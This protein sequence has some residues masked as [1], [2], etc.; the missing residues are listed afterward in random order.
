VHRAVEAFAVQP[1]RVDVAQEI[2]GGNRRPAAVQRN[3]DPSEARVDG[4]RDKVLLHCRSRGRND[5]PHE[6]EGERDE[7]RGDEDSVD[8]ARLIAA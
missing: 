3:D 6:G 2:R 1:V 4:D 5:L 7:Q 8:H